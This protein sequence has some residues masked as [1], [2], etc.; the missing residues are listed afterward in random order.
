MK[1]GIAVEAG[2]ADKIFLQPKNTYTK[3]LL[4]AAL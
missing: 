2:P 3:T 4:D 1:D